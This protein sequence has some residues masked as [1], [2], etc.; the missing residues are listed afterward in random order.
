M[1]E[2]ASEPGRCVPAWG[3]LVI[4]MA[5]GVIF[6]AHGAQKVFGFFGGHGMPG[7]YAMVR[8]LGFPLPLMFAWLAAL[9]EFLGGMGVLFGL[10]TRIAAAGIAVNMVVAIVKVHLK[11]GF[12]A[13]AG[14]E[15]PLA[16]LSMALF[17]II[18]GAGRISLDWL[19]R[20]GTRGQRGE[21]R[22]V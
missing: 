15:Y 9:A 4:R 6:M 21:P 16:L 20:Y 14:F 11:N 2:Q 8:S 7:T 12:F 5:L 10:L 17:L 22:G 1:T 13:P 19:I 3:P 18:S